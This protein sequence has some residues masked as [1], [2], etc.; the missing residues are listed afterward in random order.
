MSFNVFGSNIN[1]PSEFS[2]IMFALRQYL[3]SVRTATLAKVISC[4][5]DGG[6]S[7]VG[8]LSV[9]LLISMLD[10]EGNVTPLPDAH[11][12]P[13]VRVQGG[14]SAVIID[15][16][17]GD[18][19]IVVFGDRD[20][21]AAISTKAQS[22]PG[23]NRRFSLGDGLWIGGVLNAAPVQYMQFNANGITLKAPTITLDGNV[24]ITGTTQEDG[25]VTGNSAATYS[26]EVEGNGIKLSQHIH[27]GVQSGGSNTGLPQG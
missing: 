8:T 2:R 19:G 25:A 13:Y 23:S 12:V 17:P 15:P 14:T 26:G 16:Q 24:H 22:A 1:E 9:Q 11:E 27:P 21:S 6:V 7:P 4:T 10:A 3:G 5:N 18:L 20:L